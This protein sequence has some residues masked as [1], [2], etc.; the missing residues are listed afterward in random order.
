MLQEYTHTR[1]SSNGWITKTI[2]KEHLLSIL[3]W[4]KLVIL[5]KNKLKK[6]IEDNLDVDPSQVA[7]IM[8]STINEFISSK[9]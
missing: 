4:S 7:Y 9:E 6:T 1:S 8:K 2:R 5:A 3:N